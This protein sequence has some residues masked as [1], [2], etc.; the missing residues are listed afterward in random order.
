[1]TPSRDKSG[2]YPPREDG[3]ESGDRGGA[4]VIA[5]GFRRPA[6]KPQGD[7]YEGD[8]IAERLV[9]RLR[10]LH[11]GD[12]AVVDVIA[13]GRA[14]IPALRGLLFERDPSGIF[15]P[16][17]RAIEGLSAFKAWDV[18]IEYLSATHDV[19]D[20][21][22]RSGEEAVVSAAARRLRE[23][24]EAEFRFLLSLAP[25]HLLP[26]VIEALGSYHRAE[27]IPLLVEALGEDACRSGAEAA[28]R[29]IG[30]AAR[31]VLLLN[32]DRRRPSESYESPTSIRKRRSVM[33]L[34]L[35]IGVPA[36]ASP[37]IQ[38]LMRDADPW[39]SFYA[40]RTAA[41]WLGDAERRGAMNR[42]ID[43]LRQ[44]NWLL[45]QEIEDFL[46]DCYP[47]VQYLVERRLAS[48]GHGEG[49]GDGLRRTAEALLRIKARA[50]GTSAEGDAQPG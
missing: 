18:L 25:R 15:E 31:P 22:A 16:R 3:R 30:M 45:S 4:Q 36:S 50:R 38:G 1:M 33:R 23:M 35:D 14:T 43:L 44:E 29:A 39:V 24:G 40:C 28:L 46:A 34:L 27:A 42:M 2:E 26:G 19:V 21:V 41:R 49:R 48:V 32:A 37:L 5:A 7:G 10:S 6:G 12:A 9:E 13:H 20:P 17:L 11:D 8:R 47:N